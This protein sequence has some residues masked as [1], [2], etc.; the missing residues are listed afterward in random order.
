[1]IVEVS[2]MLFFLCLKHG[3]LPQQNVVAMIQERTRRKLGM[4]CSEC[5]RKPRITSLEREIFVNGRIQNFSYH[6]SLL[7]FI[8]H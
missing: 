3:S 6:H 8:E 5:D 4:T 7:T 2:G 1:M